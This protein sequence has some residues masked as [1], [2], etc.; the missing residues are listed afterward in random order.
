MIDR[1]AAI[2]AEYLA[3][4]RELKPLWNGN[5]SL[6][7]LPGFLLFMVGGP[8]GLLLSGGKPNQNL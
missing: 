6:L 1:E 5:F 4:L 7:F 2:I 8:D 3:R